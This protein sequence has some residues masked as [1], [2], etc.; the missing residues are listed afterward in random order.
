[1]S[2][3]SRL[4]AA[5]EPLGELSQGLLALQAKR[6]E[7]RSAT[8]LAQQKLTAEMLTSSFEE[9]SKHYNTL[10]NSDFV[11]EPTMKPL[12]DRALSSYLNA[13]QARNTF[14]GIKP[15]PQVYAWDLVNHEMMILPEDKRSWSASNLEAM[16]R[17]HPNLPDS[18]WQA[19]PVIWKAR[20]PKATKAD[21]EAGRTF[22]EG[23][24]A[25]QEDGSWIGGLATQAG[26]LIPDLL[27]TGANLFL[28]EEDKV[29]P[30]NVLWGGRESLSKIP[31]GLT[32]GDIAGYVK[33]FA[34]GEPTRDLPSLFGEPTSATTPTA[35]PS[36]RGRGGQARSSIVDQILSDP[37]PTGETSQLIPLSAV[38]ELRDLDKQ[39][40]TGTGGLMSLADTIEESQ[41]PTISQ[42]VKEFFDE[43]ILYI[44][45]YGQRQ[46]DQYMSRQFAE[47]SYPEQQEVKEILA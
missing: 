41:E 37:R 11:N 21:K 34:T 1:M 3:A 15:T 45:E 20:Q 12:L 25:G 42:K 14:F 47:L 29:D 38:E 24:G 9:A 33:D 16:K 2:T 46:A 44:Q 36:F 13:Y 31:K 30:A 5:M 17:K 10:L 39:F 26:G 23:L 43:Y 18:V 22:L 27:A 19:V 40:G 35:S 8:A 6:D 28:S 32:V 4:R 7:S